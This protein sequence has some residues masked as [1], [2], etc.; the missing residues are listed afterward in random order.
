MGEILD[1]LH[2]LQEIELQLSDLRR[3]QE[4]KARQVR[5]AQGHI[6]R[7]DDR[8]TQ[9][10]AEEATR[11]ADVDYF[12][13]DVKRREES[14]DRHRGA[15]LEAKTNKDYAAI[16]TSINTEKADKAKIERLAL[17]KLGE[18]ERVQQ[19]AGDC[20]QERFAA[21][22]RLDA[23]KQ[24]L[25]EYLDS[26]AEQRQTLE[27][28]RDAAARELPASTLATFSRVAEKHNGEA[29]A[30]VIRL[31]PR[32]EEYAC[33]GCHMTVTLDGVSAL[34]SRDEVQFCGA[35]GRILYMPSPAIPEV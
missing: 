30:E 22:Q 34:L 17:E 12:D 31:H 6:R 19:V 8:I 28:E 26:T 2:R 4:R 3:G 1:A 10:Q 29:L 23:C 35:C 20:R 7:L 9:L 32:R 5:N 27:A 33:G 11:Q 18:L 15:L 24:A 13:G 21:E 14:I 16:L 25:Q